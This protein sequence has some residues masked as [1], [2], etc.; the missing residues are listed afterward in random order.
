MLIS[1]SPE[2]AFFSQLCRTDDFAKQHYLVVDGG[3]SAYQ[4]QVRFAAAA[5]GAVSI[6]PGSKSCRSTSLN[7][8]SWQGRRGEAQEHKQKWQ[9]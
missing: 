4:Q 9:A 8:G 5:M 6:N 7:A 1:L 2:V 3:D